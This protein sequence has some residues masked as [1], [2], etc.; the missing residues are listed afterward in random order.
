[1]V[2]KLMY[3]SALM[4][5]RWYEPVLYHVTDVSFPSQSTEKQGR[6][7]GVADYIGDALTY[8]I[9]DDVTEQVIPRSVMH[10]VVRSALNVQ[11]PNLRAASSSQQ[12][13]EQSG[14]TAVIT[15]LRDMLPPS[16]DPA[17][18]A[19]PAFLHVT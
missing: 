18:V 8:L 13:G 3:V 17:E 2:R 5:F 11:H 10:S 9:L 6:W 4:Q 7:V 16:V 15:S 12:D 1:M 19:L 14:G